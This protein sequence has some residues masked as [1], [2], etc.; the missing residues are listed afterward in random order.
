MMH[1]DLKQFKYYDALRFRLFNANTH[2]WRMK[3]YKTKANNRI[4]NQGK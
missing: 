2:I 3:D 4:Q 1:C